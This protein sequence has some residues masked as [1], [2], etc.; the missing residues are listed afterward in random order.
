MSVT[1]AVRLPALGTNPSEQF[2]PWVDGWATEET[3]A[4]KGGQGAEDAAYASAVFIEHCHLNG[5]EVTGGAADIFKCFDQVMRPLIYQLLEAAGL[6]DKVLRPYIDFQER[7]KAYN[8]VAGGVGKPFQKPTS[9]PQGDPLSMMVVALLMRACVVEMKSLNVKPRV[10]A[11]DLQILS[12][13]K[14]QLSKFVYAFDMTHAHLAA[15]GARLAPN[16][17]VVF[18]SNGTARKWLRQ[19]R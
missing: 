19:H 16:K 2:R 3:Y 1:D 4:G 14:D 6:P 17:S 7:L 8:T 13:G 11:D 9:I 18:S 10:L 15:M 5:H 12:H